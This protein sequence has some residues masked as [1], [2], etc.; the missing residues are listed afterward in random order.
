MVNVNC[1]FQHFLRCFSLLYF[2][3]Y[4]MSKINCKIE[5]EYDICMQYSYLI[6]KWT[7]S[8]H[9]AIS[10]IHLALSI[11]IFVFHFLT[12]IFMFNAKNRITFPAFHY[13][14]LYFK[15]LIVFK[16]YM[17]TFIITIKQHFMLQKNNCISQMNIPN[18]FQMRSNIPI[19]VVL[20]FRK[21]KVTL[22]KQM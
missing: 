21:K 12:Y 3:A 17:W 15:L 7:N 11:P 18:W 10:I 2:T 19:V 14:T 13:F 9:L 22:W 6:C 20:C 8:I 16:S 1:W 5:V 4:I